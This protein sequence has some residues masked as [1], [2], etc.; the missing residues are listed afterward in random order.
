MTPSYVWHDV[1]IHYLSIWHAWCVAVCYSVLQCD[2][3]PSRVWHKICIHHFLMYRACC[4][5]R[6]AACCSVLQ[7]VK[8]CCTVLHCVALCCTVSADTHAGEA[9]GHIT[10]MNESYK[11]VTSHVW[12]RHATH[13]D[14]SRHKYKW[15]M[16]YIWMS[17]T[18]EWVM[19]HTY[20]RVTVTHHQQ[21][22]ET[23]QVP[24]QVRRCVMSHVWMD[25]FTRTN[26]V[27][28]SYIYGWVMSH[29]W[30]S[31]V[32]HMNESRWI[33]SHIRM[34]HFTR[35]NE[36]CHSY[37]YGWVMSHIWISRVTHMNESRSH[38]I[39]RFKRQHRCPC[40][41]NDE[42][43]HT[44]EQM[45][46]HIW[47]SH[48]T[49]EWVM[50]HIWM[51]H[52]THIW[53]SHG[54]TPSTDSRGSTGAH[55]GEAMSHVTHMNESFH[56]YE[57]GMSIIYIWMSHVTHMNESCHTHMNESRSHTINRFE[58][59]HRCPC[60]WSDESLEGVALNTRTSQHC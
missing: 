58:R 2:M 31:H 19:S 12:M 27:C 41:W 56:T 8:L 18:W 49:D 4:T 46:S 9:M 38:T 50:S 32:T 54:H 28:H 25:H 40:R 59:Q 11:W 23:A 33:M 26:E 16:P 47:I 43:R 37:V 60:R 39:N 24:M 52:V 15:F 21:T 45:R 42:S 1:F 48:H 10:H 34:N 44:Y 13:I 20:E 14:E 36:V 29:I 55:A 17:H 3:T 30:I 53:T 35:T 5:M 6:V 57:W 51:S 22:R 7:C